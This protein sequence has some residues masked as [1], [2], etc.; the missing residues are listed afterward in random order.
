MRE[1][2]LLSCL[3]VLVVSPLPAQRLDE[4]DAPAEVRPLR[5]MR[6]AKWSTL[7]VAAGTAAWGFVQN[8]KA[9][10]A[11]ADLERRCNAAPSVCARRTP[12]GAYEDAEL[13]RR[14]QNVRSLDRRAHAALLLG[15][16]G[17]ATSAV[18]FLLDLGN[19]RRPPDIPFTP[20][21]IEVQPRADGAVALSVRV[22]LPFR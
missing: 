1:I 19:A 12:D 6:V 5:P 4:E 17:I 10:D 14:Y 18:L 20:T 8:G 11:F 22:P 2:L 7:V 16:I 15:Q 13:E 9:D 3:M 21:E